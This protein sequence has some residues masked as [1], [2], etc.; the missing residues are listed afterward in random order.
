MKEN[1]FEKWNDDR[2]RTWLR[3]EVVTLIKKTKIEIPDSVISEAVSNV[4]KFLIEEGGFKEEGLDKKM[5]IDEAKILLKDS[6]IKYNEEEYLL[7]KFGFM[8]VI[9]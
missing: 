6:F 8:T 9:E 1:V 2:R 4:N 7:P 3:N 5:E